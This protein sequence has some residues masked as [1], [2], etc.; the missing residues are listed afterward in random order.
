M[1]PL[2]ES[3]LLRCVDL[4]PA[5]PPA[6]EGLYGLVFMPILPIVVDDAESLLAP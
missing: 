6:D 1:I 3:K 2:F 4:P 5:S